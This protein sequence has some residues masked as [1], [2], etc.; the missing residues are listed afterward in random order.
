[1][2][3][4]DWVKVGTIGVDSGSV[5][6]GDPCYVNGADASH[7]AKTW[8]DFLE[9]TWPFTFDPKEGFAMTDIQK[10]AKSKS[11]MDVA[12]VMGQAGIGIVVSSGY[13]DGEYPVYIRK[14]A[15]GRIMGLMV[16]FDD[17]EDEND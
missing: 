11:E 15:E 12:N 14:N 17:D 9:K 2:H 16:N 7:G 8:N 4:D 1:M 5:A 6:V 13:G 10:A 3:Y